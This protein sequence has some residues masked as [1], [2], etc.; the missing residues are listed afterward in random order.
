MLLEEF[1]PDLDSAKSTES[2]EKSYEHRYD[3][4]DEEKDS[5][6]GSSDLRS[7]ENESVFDDRKSMS[8]TVLPL[9]LEQLVKEALAELKPMGWWCLFYHLNDRESGFE[10]DFI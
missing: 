6:D 7:N 3:D 10:N 4:S 9:E 1:L 5:S 8:K 2:K